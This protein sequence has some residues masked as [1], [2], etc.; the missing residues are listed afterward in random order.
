VIG[1]DSR[2][3]WLLVVVPILLAAAG[4]D[5]A[6]LAG[7]GVRGW[8][9]T[10]LQAVE[11]RPLLL[12]GDG[13]A[14]AGPCLLPQSERVAVAG[15]QD[16]SLT[17]WGMGVRGLSASVFLRGRGGF[18]SA[19]VW[20]RTGDHFDAL[21]AY[22]RYVRG[23]LTFRL[24]RQEI[25][26]GL[27]FSSFDG[28]TAV[29]RRAGLETEVYG[30]RSLARGLRD[31]AN[32][33]LRGIEDYVPDQGIY[34]WGG[35]LRSRYRLTTIA[36]RYQ[37]EIL[38]DRSG[39]ASE[40]ASLDAN[41]TWSWARVTAGMDYDFGAAQ[42][43]KGHVT[44]TSPLSGGRWMLSATARRYVPYFSL[45]TI[46]GFFEPVAY[47]EALGRVGWS[48]SRMVGLWASAGRRSYGDTQ[49]TVVLRPLEDT[50]WRTEVGGRWSPAQSW[51]ID[52]DY[53]VEWGPGAFLQSLNGSLTWRPDDRLSV[54][55]SATT[56]QQI[57]Q[58]RLGDGRAWGG[59]FAVDK[60]VADRLGLSAGM[61]ML[62]LSGDG[63]AG[64]DPWNQSRAWSSLRWEIGSD[65]GLANRVRR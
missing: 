30:G 23:P 6:A 16:V 28:A 27:G 26:S 4:V 3:G 63:A 29:W 31:P 17:V 33:A 56:F 42:I 49:T 50:G 20:P 55:A 36:A 65:P 62:R 57:E 15:T 2:L 11:L 34:L 43:G 12:T 13:C 37:R 60:R 21:L 25:R 53:E 54:R 59:G 35:A 1:P 52:G 39:L 61:S 38:A 47:H 48:P 58:F 9:G 18:G 46:W 40:R 44:V 64:R 7:Q 14:D 8:A 22:A 10:T 24:G 19:A 5:P 51:S 41:T 45:S 32:E